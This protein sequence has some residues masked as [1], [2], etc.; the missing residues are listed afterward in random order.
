MGQEVWFCPG[1]LFTFTS[2]FSQLAFQ[3][4]FEASKWWVKEI[5]ASFCLSAPA[6]TIKNYNLSNGFPK[7]KIIYF[8]VN[9]VWVINILN[10]RQ[11]N[12]SLDKIPFFEKSTNPVLFRE[13]GRNWYFLLVIITGLLIGGLSL[14]SPWLAVGLIIGVAFIVLA[15]QK[16]IIL[17]YFLII[18]VTLTSGIPRGRLIPMFGINEA[19]LVLSFG[20]AIL[21]AL[22]NNRSAKLKND[23]GFISFLFLVCGGVFLPIS[24]YIFQ[25]VHLTI[26]NSF[27]LFTPIQY[28][29]VF[30]IFQTIPETEKERTNLIY[31]M[32]AC[33]LVIA[34]VGLLQI[35]GV[36]FV[37]S[38]LA[39]FYPSSHGLVA[40]EVRRVTSLLGAWNATGMFLMLST[41]LTWALLSS[42]IQFKYKRQLIVALILLLACLIATGSYASVISLALGIFLVEALSRHWIKNIPKNAILF[43]LIFLAMM[44]L[45]PVLMPIVSNRL[46]FQSQDG[47]LLPSTLVFRFEVWEKVFLPPIL[48]SF[49]WAVAPKVPE[50]YAWGF[51]ESQYIMLQFHTGLFGLASFIG[52]IIYTL[53]F[54]QK[55]RRALRGFSYMV[56][57]FTMVL[58]FILT[59]AGL[60]N[61]VF[62]YSGV[63]EY[64]WILLA[65]SATPQ[66]VVNA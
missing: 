24:V 40:V 7:S 47:G 28:F 55:R 19:G 63:A 11:K 14:A 17:C 33:G 34:C 10:M 1:K 36:G 37:N 48:E 30:W 15:L 8:T 6:A 27:N 21:A 39:K 53:F 61:A 18:L 46:S 20:I 2:T 9:L 43:G 51:A 23:Y 52:W 29:M 22:S 35:I 16:P 26:S 12:S 45:Q 32:I 13:G 25:G 49:P 65:F 58:V 57:S 3:V 64:M 41:V 5:C 59:I 50:T 60:T 31:L 4:L 62:T 54:L 56:A 42:D 66:I 38:F 44:L